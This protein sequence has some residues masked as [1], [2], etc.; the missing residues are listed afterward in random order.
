MRM[1]ATIN[2]LALLCAPLAAAGL[3]ACAA[4]PLVQGQEGGQRAEQAA[5]ANEVLKQHCL[6]CHGDDKAEDF[7]QFSFFDRATLEKKKILVPGKPDQSKLMKR[8]TSEKRRMPPASAEKEPLSAADVEV[9]KDWIAAGAPSFSEKVVVAPSPTPA[10]VPA[11]TDAPGAR[12]HAIFNDHCAQCHGGAKPEGAFRIDDLEQLRSKEL[13]IPKQPD[14][15][16]LLARIIAKDD[17]MPPADKGLAPLSEA[18]IQAVRAWIEAGAPDFEAFAK[19]A[20]N[21]IGDEYVL[22]AIVR[23]VREHAGANERLGAYRYFSLNHLLAAG[24][25]ENE[26]EAH[27]QALT[28]VMNHLSRK[29][30]FA[31]PEPIEPTRTV[32]RVDISRLGWDRQ[33]LVKRQGGKTVP[34]DLTLWDLVLLDYPYGMI[35]DGSDTYRQVNREFLAPVHQV[36]PVAYVRG[37]WFVNTASRPPLYED[38]LQLPF[39]FQGLQKQLDVDVEDNL[40]NARLKRAAF[41]LSGVSR[42]NRSV[43][44]HEPNYSAYLWVSYDYKSNKG[45]DNI[46]GDP[47]HLNPTGGEMI[48]NLP[49]GLQGYY[50]ANGKGTRLEVAPTEIVTDP[51]ASD[52]AVHNGLACMRCH[53]N[54]GMKTFRDDVRPLLDQLTGSPAAFDRQDALRVYPR[55]A[56]MESAVRHDAGIF[57]RAVKKLFAAKPPNIHYVLDTVSSRFLDKEINVRVAA[58]ELGVANPAQIEKAFQNQRLASAGLA[59]LASGGAVRRDNWEDSYDQVAE[60]FSRGIPVIPIDGIARTDYKRIDSRLDVEVKPN[61]KTFKGGDKLVI[62]IKNTSEVPLFVE[63]VGVGSKGERMALTADVCRIAAGGELSLPDDGSEGYPTSATTGRE[64]V[65]VY[66]CDRQFEKGEALTF[67]RSE[68]EKGFGMAARF[69]H[70]QFYQL[71]EDG[72]HF[73]PAF[74]V[75]R[76]I[77]K[78]IELET[79]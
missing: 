48:F 15:S 12:V 46:F 23:D 20:S 16:T 72:E 62:K 76:M 71:P 6:K 53:S 69:V 38:L 1:S 49:N 43:E 56:E 78:T 35:S 61:R 8:I 70:H 73:R 65:T 37:D 40:K 32:F 67:P 42:N 45:T 33:R 77:K 34:A 58:E 36:R 11:P 5:R 7:E 44:R 9:L 39:T 3:L 25:T 79:Q 64:F 41:T 24:M 22:R 19:A 75:G 4:L 17:R 51:D 55:Q 13:V 28:L 14:K 21:Q 30:D 29:A 2:R 66:A 52:K 47:I 27:R 59:Q 68:A 57:D 18:D 60:E 31:L 54:P 63:V 10:E 50:V 74:D 26:L